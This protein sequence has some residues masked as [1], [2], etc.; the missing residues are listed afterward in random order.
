MV[1]VDQAFIRDPSSLKALNQQ[2]SNLSKDRLR[3][4][5]KMVMSPHAPNDED[6]QDEAFLELN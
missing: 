1:E 2:M 5:L 3:T 6:L 4:C